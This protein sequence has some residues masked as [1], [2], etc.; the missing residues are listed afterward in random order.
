MVERQGERSN[1]DGGSTCPK[2]CRADM[3]PSEECRVASAE[4]GIELREAVGRA[5]TQGEALAAA[6]AV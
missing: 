5:I 6:R 3:P 4:W 2:V 1:C